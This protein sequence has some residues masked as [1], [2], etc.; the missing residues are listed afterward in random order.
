[1]TTRLNTREILLAARKLIRKGWT[2]NTHA[3]GRSKRAVH[4]NSRS[5]VCFCLDG[6]LLRAGD[7]GRAY[8]FLRQFDP[9]PIAFNDTPGRKKSEVIALLTKAIE[10]AP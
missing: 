4:Y 6:A 3:R 2:Q 1:M 7:N 8:D 10:A 5:A 9:S